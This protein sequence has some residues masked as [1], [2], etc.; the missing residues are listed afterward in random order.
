MTFKEIFLGEHPDATSEFDRDRFIRYAFE[1]VRNQEPLD[2]AALRS[3]HV[4]E[5][6]IAHYQQG[7]FWISEVQRM[8]DERLLS[9]SPT[10]P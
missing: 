4:S 1:A 5:R 2:V 8:I 9:L 3:L 6:M 10:R 7:F